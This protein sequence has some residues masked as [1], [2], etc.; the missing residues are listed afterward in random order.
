MNNM[1]QKISISEKIGYSLGDCSA[2]LVFQMM[3]IYQTKFYTDVF[4]L[5]GAIAGSVMLIA[6]IVDAFVDP[7]VGILSDKTQTRWGKY[8][9]WILWTA[10][11]FMVFYVLAFYNP[12]IEDK[13]LVAVYATISY[14][15]L[16]TL[17]SFNNTPYASLGG[18][19]TSDIKERNS[20][21]SIRFVA[22]T[23][24]QFVVQGLTLPLV[25]K[26]AGAD[27]DK[28]HGWL[29]TISLFAVIG[30]VFF[31]IT[32]FSARERITPPASQKTDTRKDIK[33]VFR[34]IPW[35]AM[36]ILTLFLFTTLA[37]WGSAM[38]YYFEN[39]VDANALYTFLD[40]LGLVA[41]EA[42]A[43]LS[44]NILNAFGLI[45]NG[46]EKAYEVGF[47]VFNMVGAL[48]Q[49]FGVILLSSFLANRYG[50]K[51][52]FIICL[53]LTAIFTAL[54]YFPN[55][56]DIETM[57]A[58]NFLKSL[59]YA[60]TVPLLWAMIA[61]VADHSEYVNY[62][63][64]TGFVFAGVVFALKAGL[65]IGGAILGFLL[66]GFGYVSGAGTAQTES[67]IHGIILS[68]S[69]IP[70]AT[71]FI[72]VIALYFYPITKAYNEKMQAELTERRKQTD[73]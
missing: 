5:E 24:A 23:V 6:R 53:T 15:L 68:S 58:L 14:T 29:C 20:I 25:G 7:T 31:I 16:M 52:V 19:M 56:T 18:V 59:A 51:R 70:A 10:L 67:A 32:F 36:F 60:P 11:P 49:F 17:Y 37:M 66:S 57:F 30:F 64:A 62:R 54:F 26:F 72:G 50:K 45:V 2:N 46:P 63:R 47:G 71:F 41:V 21:T 73:Y 38:N 3:M 42:N 4:G 43:S 33:D 9:P 22:A 39:Y 8:R 65:G 28:G 44:Y 35:R 13:S 12:G 27:G 61:D 69:L 1:N 40:K 34:N 55:E 48:V